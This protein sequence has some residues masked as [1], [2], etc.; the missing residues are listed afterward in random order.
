MSEDRSYAVGGSVALESFGVDEEL[1]G[2]GSRDTVD[3]AL[4]TSKEGVETRGWVGDV[5]DGAGHISFR[6]PV[7]ISKD[8]GACLSNLF[9]P[10]SDN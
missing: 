3:L 1:A 7:W 8:R 9:C 4:V 5:V 2:L 10:I 6:Q